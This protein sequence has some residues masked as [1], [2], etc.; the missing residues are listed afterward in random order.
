[1]WTDYISEKKQ[2]ISIFGNN[3]APGNLNISYAIFGANAI[4]LKLFSHI[5]GSGFPEKWIKNDYNEYSFDLI[6]NNVDAV[7]IT[8][9]NFD[10]RL[11]LSIENDNKEYKIKIKIGTNCHFACTASGIFVSNIKSY[12][13]DGAT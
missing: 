5:E 13:N 3:Y 9:F 2:W 4:T 6:I 7:E 11:Q 8:D 12:K 10:G 1:M